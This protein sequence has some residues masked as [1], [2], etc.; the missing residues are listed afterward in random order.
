MKDVAER[1]SRRADEQAGFATQNAETASEQKRV[2]EVNAAKAAADRDVAV[3]AREEAKKAAGEAETARGEA[4]RQTSIATARR[5]A[6]EALSLFG[7]SA[8]ELAVSGMVAVKSL[9]ADA[10]TDGRR[11][12]AQ[13][14]RLVPVAPE[15]VSNVHVGPVLGLAFSLNGRWMAS[16][17]QDGSVVI[18]DLVNQKKRTVLERQFDPAPV[19]PG[20][21]FSDDGRWLVAGSNYALWIWST[22]TGRRVQDP[23]SS[24]FVRSI[25]FSPDGLRFAAAER[26]GSV[27]LFA[28]AGET[29]VESKP[30]LSSGSPRKANGVVF[31]SSDT[32]ALAGSS[33]PSLPLENLWSWNLNAGKER[34]LDLGQDTETL[35]ECRALSRSGDSLTLAAICERGILMARRTD[36]G[37]ERAAHRPS[38]AAGAFSVSYGL[39]LNGNGTNVAAKANDG[40][41]NVFGE[42][43]T[44]ERTRMFVSGVPARSVA[45]RPDGRVVAA[46]L[47][48]G[49]VVFWPT[50]KGAEAIP[51]RHDGAVGGLAFSHDA[52]WLV[53]AGDN[54][55]RAFEVS[56]GADAGSLRQRLSIPMGPRLRSPA[57]SPDDRFVAVLDEKALQVFGRAATPWKALT[58]LEVGA[59]A[60]STVF[61][62]KSRFLLVFEPNL[63]RILDTGTW[64]EKPRIRV[65]RGGEAAISPDG[66][67]LTYHTNRLIRKVGRLDV[68]QVWRL[69]DGVETAWR[70]EGEGANPARPARGGPQQLI[71]ESATWTVVNESESLRRAGA[72]SAEME[73]SSPTLTLFNESGTSIAKLE[74]D[75]PVTHFAFSPGGRWLA[76]S[77]QDGTLRLWPL[78]VKDLLVQ[79]CKLLPRNLTAE[80]WKALSLDGP[81][82]KSCP[83]LP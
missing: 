71:E 14:L 76:S 38:V 40:V 24:Q 77:S 69:S 10:T 19:Q 29:W 48:N 7:P 64:Q 79:A 16:T 65:D 26:G 3:A 18:W 83:S 74:H 8:D 78:Q 72:W 56:T 4:Q 63:I 67:F 28:R 49:S 33:G 22:E 11:A 61:S 9:E 50:S 45:F 25:A 52:R 66:Q 70:E 27:R 55:I 68:R 35:G 82:R 62:P 2:A 46:G 42:P 37:L 17:G 51:S 73:S 30:V 34:M 81:Y 44:S 39:A 1:Q 43:I 75:G 21:V 60:I 32:L 23:I 53:T 15:I 36:A 5:L 54:S 41:I 12:L 13:V 31:L 6:T 20:L 59:E 58:R 47:E 80:E 57:F